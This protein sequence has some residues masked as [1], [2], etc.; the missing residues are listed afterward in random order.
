MKSSADNIALR[1][2]KNGVTSSVDLNS[3]SSEVQTNETNA[4]SLES[5]EFPRMAGPIPPE[6]YEPIYC[7]TNAC[8]MGD[9]YSK[10]YYSRVYDSP[11][12]APSGA[13][14]EPLKTDLQA[15]GQYEAKALKDFQANQEYIK[16]M[17]AETLKK[18]APNEVSHVDRSKEYAARRVT[19]H[20]AVQFKEQQA[21]STYRANYAPYVVKPVEACPLNNFYKDA[22]YA[23]TVQMKV[24]SSQTPMSIIELQ[25]RWT[26]SKANKM[27]NIKYKSSMPDLRCNIAKGKRRLPNAP[28][29]EQYVA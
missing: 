5:K 28:N 18:S 6:P 19:D 25:D 21:L 26:K 11:H 22:A 1:N 13:R 15:M 20:T 9:G 16:N 8:E 2:Y 4:K 24:N 7:S 12:I 10:R 27:H 23:E 17:Q 14:Y 29:C 3:A